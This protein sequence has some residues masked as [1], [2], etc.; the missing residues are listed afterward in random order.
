MC[1]RKF[2]Y[3]VIKNKKPWPPSCPE[4]SSPFNSFFIGGFVA[5]FLILQSCT[6]VSE[7]SAQPVWPL[8]AADTL[9]GFLS[10]NPHCLPQHVMHSKQAASRGCQPLC[11]RQGGRHYDHLLPRQKGSMERT[12]ASD[13]H[14]QGGSL[15]STVHSL[16]KLS[17]LQS[18]HCLNEK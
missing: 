8:R 2:F 13:R 3:F 17:G 5:F 11:Q 1:S 4:L 6:E 9:F 15:R 14:S 16:C 10:V 18:L 7:F 12:R